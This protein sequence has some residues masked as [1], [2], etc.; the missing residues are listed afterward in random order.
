MKNINLENAKNFK[1]EL[2]ILDICSQLIDG[3]IEIEGYYGMKTF[4]FKEV[5]ENKE[6]V[7]SHAKRMQ[8]A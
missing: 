5:A 6:M 7:L 2:L 4:S 3:Y 1:K 8:Y